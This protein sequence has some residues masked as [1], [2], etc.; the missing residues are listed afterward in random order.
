MR[1][2]FGETVWTRDSRALDSA[3]WVPW[4]S[5]YRWI[6]PFRWSLVG[7]QTVL[8]RCNCNWAVLSVTLVLIDAGRPTEVRY[9]PSQGTL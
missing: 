6:S 9:E 7:R 1:G 2:V 3:A 8:C 4:P 5:L